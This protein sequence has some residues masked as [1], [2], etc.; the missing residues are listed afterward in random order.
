MFLQLIW[1]FC[2]NHRPNYPHSLLCLIIPGIPRLYLQKFMLKLIY[3][4]IGFKA[5]SFYDNFELISV[6]ICY[7]NDS[8]KVI[9][10]LKNLVVE[11]QA[12][13]LDN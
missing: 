2:Y 7:S 13:N 12:L 10:H 8:G 9:N 5:P 4:K 3:R 1:L 6:P 11:R